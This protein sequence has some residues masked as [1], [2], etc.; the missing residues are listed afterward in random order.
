LI[1]KGLDKIQISTGTAKEG[2]DEISTLVRVV[3]VVVFT[4]GREREREKKTEKKE[5]STRPCPWRCT[6]ISH[7]IVKEEGANDQ[8]KKHSSS[9]KPRPNHSQE[10]L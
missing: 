10:H 6:H 7:K 5:L 8:K 2:S 3:V 9:N 4:R 1:K